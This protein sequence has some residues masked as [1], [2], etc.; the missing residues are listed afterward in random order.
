MFWP[1]PVSKGNPLDSLGIKECVGMVWQN[2][3]CIFKGESSDQEYMEAGL[4]GNG[5]MEE[6][7]REKR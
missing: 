3:T 4:R 7:V 6:V 1:Y 5:G 2:E